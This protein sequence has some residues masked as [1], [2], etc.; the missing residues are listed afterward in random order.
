MAH[1][2][3]AITPYRTTERHFQPCVRNDTGMPLFIRFRPPL[4]F[5]AH[6]KGCLSLQNALFQAAKQAISCPEMGFIRP[7]YGLFD[8]AFWALSFYMCV[9]AD[10]THVI[11]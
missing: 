2:L 8:N 9:L 3:T 1:T 10:R 7:Q 4:A 5:I 6:E 11:S